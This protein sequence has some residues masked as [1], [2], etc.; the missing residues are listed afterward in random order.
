[1]TNYRKLSRRELDQICYN[2]RG[3]WPADH[4]TDQ[5][6]HD[7]LHYKVDLP[8]SREDAQRATLKAYIA[9]NR[10][11]ITLLCDGDCSAHCNLIVR[12]CY[13][14]FKEDTRA[15]STDD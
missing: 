2:Q 7:F 4:C 5:E 15:D 10:E 6:V 3:R 13:K 1:M 9:E 11:C 8:P 14:E 12:M